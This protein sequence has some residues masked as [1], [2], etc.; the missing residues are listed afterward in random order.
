[1]FV[2]ATAALRPIQVYSYPVQPPR[3]RPQLPECLVAMFL[4]KLSI[5]PH[6]N[7]LY[8]DSCGYVYKFVG[9][10][11]CSCTHL[12]KGGYICNGH[13]TRHWTQGK[14]QVELLRLMAQG[15]VAVAW[16]LAEPS[17]PIGLCVCESYL[18]DTVIKAIDF[19]M[20]VLGEIYG[21]LGRQEPFLV[22]THLSLEGVDPLQLTP[23]IEKFIYGLA[24]SMMKRLGLFQA[25]IIIPVSRKPHSKECEALNA[26]FGSKQTILALDTRH[27]RHRELWGVR[28]K[29][30]ND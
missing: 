3:T 19:P 1:M 25:T 2:P 17:V 26:L 6:Q 29:I 22:F 15:C 24:E 13:I 9:R 18:S 23:V 8:C 28:F 16:E 20:S 4:R 12:Q 5:E 11:G 27:D 10:E 14:A 30:R 21:R 7:D